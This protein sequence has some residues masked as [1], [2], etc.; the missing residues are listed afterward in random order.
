[1]LA[2]CRGFL[3]IRLLAS[4]LLVMSSKSS[5]AIDGE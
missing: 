5:R 2:L 1:V 3:V 4:H